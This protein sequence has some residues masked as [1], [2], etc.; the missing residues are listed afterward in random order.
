MH[1]KLFGGPARELTALPS[2]S[3]FI[4]LIPR[5]VRS[6]EKE[7]TEKGE[8]YENKERGKGIKKRMRNEMLRSTVTFKSAPIRTTVC[9]A[10]II[11]NTY[12]RVAEAPA[13]L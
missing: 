9:K 10:A 1:Q 4:T 7:G 13:V 12:T 8:G 6:R 11:R 3:G 2:R 5:Q